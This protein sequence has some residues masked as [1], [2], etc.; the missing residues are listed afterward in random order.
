MIWESIAW[1]TAIDLGIATLAIALI[2]LFRSHRVEVRRLGLSGGLA[3]LLA[4]LSITALFYLLDLATMHALPPL[5]GE[6]RA[7][8]LMRDLHLNWNWLSTGISVGLVGLGLGLLLRRLIPA[9]AAAL[10]RSEESVTALSGR[11]GELKR[12]VE[13]GERRYRDLVD[14][15]VLGVLIHR[16]FEIL[17]ANPTFARIMGYDQPRDL[18]RLGVL[19]LYA[20][21]EADRLREF[22]ERRLRGE[23]VPTRYEVNAIRRD[24]KP[25]VIQHHVRVVDWEGGE[26]VQTTVADITELNEAELALRQGE[27]RLRGFIDLALDAVVIIDSGSRIIDWNAQAEKVFGWSAA[28]AVGKLLTET[29]IPARYAHA[30]L[31]GLERFLDSGSGEV[32]RRRI[33]VTARDRA[34]RE[35]PAELTVLPFFQN[36]DW[37]FGAFVR[38]VSLLEGAEKWRR[39]QRQVLEMIATQHPLYDTLHALCVHIEEVCGGTAAVVLLD[40]SA[41]H[42]RQCIAPR[43]APEY[44]G[45]FVGLPATAEAAPCGACVS[46]RETLF[47]ADLQSDGRWPDHATLSAAH[48]I[49]CS[50]N[51]PI[52]LD[53]YAVGAFVLSHA[54]HPTATADDGDNLTMAASLAGI[55]VSRE[56]AQQEV[57]RHQE[58]LEHLVAERTTELERAVGEIESFSYSVSHDLRAPLRAIDGYSYILLEDYAEALGEDGRGTLTRI[59]GASQKMGRLIDDI[60]SLS[61]MSRSRMRL[62]PVDLSAL[63]GDAVRGL[64]E[65]EPGRR[66]EVQ[67]EPG[68]RTTGDPALLQVL[69]DNLIGNAWKY[70]APREVARIEVGQQQRGGERAF[71]VRDNGVGFDMKYADKL[72]GPFQ[73]L[74]GEHEFEGSGI[75]LATV[76]RIVSRHGGEVWA[77]SEPGKGSTFGFQLWCASQVPS[78]SATGR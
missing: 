74:H 39:A 51:A 76:A 13:A 65:G 26:A 3:L 15:A 57:H 77:H 48:R 27:Q 50:W 67:I 5:I 32:M 24:G 58:N 28:E 52:V 23:A 44:A 43:L 35:F 14:G 53:G 66:V 38:D 31:E 73:R 49:E 1:M 75:G 11:E 2:M 29:I 69:I 19:D 9:A 61:R 33:V 8:A 36:Q 56:R 46:G 78:L 10:E 64:R 59:R 47:V 18:L 22:N 30:H 7:M 16:N 34:G 40:E 45:S 25:I 68:L 21:H 72:F 60:L 17:Y 42:F 41:S 12:R 54:G 37:V 20:P 62:Q 55:A 63:A 70:S 4:G 6:P 71:Y